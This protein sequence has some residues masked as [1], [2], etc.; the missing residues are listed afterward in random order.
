M[1]SL[2]LSLKVLE[3]GKK[4][5]T[6]STV[7]KRKINGKKIL[8]AFFRVQFKKMHSAHY[9]LFKIKMSTSTVN[10][11]KITTNRNNNK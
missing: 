7:F 10:N 5:F 1:V 2:Q 9:L 4:V 8:S 3:Q 6:D 11:K